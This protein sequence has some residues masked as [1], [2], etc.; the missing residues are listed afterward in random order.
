MDDFI[1]DAFSVRPFP[2]FPLAFGC[3]YRLKRTG[4]ESGGFHR[5]IQMR[6][7][8]PWTIPPQLVFQSGRSL[9]SPALRSCLSRL[10]KD[11]DWK[12]RLSSP[13]SDER[14]WSLDDSTPVGLSGRPFPELPRNFA[15]A[16]AA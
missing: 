9:N 5:R 12:Q 3:E 6:G 14:E 13:L 7:N 8:G 11:M 1:P 15:A 10:K 16:K 2:C 4:T